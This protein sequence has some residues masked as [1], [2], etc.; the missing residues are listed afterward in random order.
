[1]SLILSRDFSSVANDY[2]VV[3]E[4]H[5][6]ARFLEELLLHARIDNCSIGCPHSSRHGSGVA[7]LASYLKSLQ[8]MIQIGAASLKGLM[9]VVDADGDAGTPSQWRVSGLP[10][11][12]FPCRRSRLLS[13]LVPP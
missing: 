8:G 7:A 10:R 1:M 2:L 3:C 12:N 13:W 6:D 11:Q 9:V 4:G 5:N